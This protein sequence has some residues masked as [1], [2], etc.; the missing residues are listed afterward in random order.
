VAGVRHAVR[1]GTA[2]CLT[3]PN[4]AGKSTLALVLGGLAAPVG[5]ELVAGAALRAGLRSASPWRWRSRQLVTRIGTVFQEPRHQFV[6]RTVAEELAVGPDRVGLQPAEVQRRTT[7][8]LER[9]H[10]AHLA[11]ANPFT[12]SGGEQRRLSVATALATR[13]QVLVLDEPTFGQDARTWAELAALL[14]GLLEDGAAV[15][16]ATHDEALV[17]ALGGREL[18]LPAR[19][20]TGS[21]GEAGAAD[22]DPPEPAAVAGAHGPGGS[23]S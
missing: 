7:E 1:A 16:A 2:T 11:R 19:R 20:R 9:L 14:L 21:A 4:G 6:A 22:G 10:L 15:V 12:L 17:T 3:G 18:A 23:R 8:L 13:P 5:G